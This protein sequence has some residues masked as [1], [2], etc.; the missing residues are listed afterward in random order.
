MKNLSCCNI[1][2]SLF[3]KLFLKL[4]VFA[5]IF[6]F[7]TL[8]EAAPQVDVA[9][10]K[11]ASVTI[12]NQSASF[13][14][15]LAITNTDTNN[16]AKTL[17]VSDNLPNGMGLISASGTDWACT[18]S[19]NPI[20]VTCTR[21]EL[22]KNSSSQ[23]TLNVTAPT[24]G[25]GGIQTITNT[26]TI[27][28]TDTTDNN[29]ANNSSSVAVTLNRPPIATDE[30]V[31]T[32]SH[33]AISGNVLTNDSDLDG[34]T[35][36]VTNTGTFT[37]SY[38]S[39]T[40][41]SNG[42][43]TYN[44]GYFSGETDSYTYTVSD[45]K[46]G[47]ATATL[48]I[49]IGSECT[50]T[51]LINAEREFCLRKQTVLFGD[52]VT[53]GNSILVPPT[54]QNS[55]VCDS[56]TTGAYYTDSPDSEENHEL[57]LCNY[58]PDSYTN[59]T[60]AEVVM[61]AT[62]KI[63]WA[64]LYLQSIV[65]QSDAASLA[66]MDIKIKNGN[67]SYVSAGTPTVINH[68]QYFY[69]NSRNYNAYSA[70]IDVTAILTS[71]NW[72]GGVYSV[73][74]VPVTTDQFVGSMV[75][76][77]YGAWT[78][79]VMYENMTDSLKSFSVYDG[80]EQFKYGNTD[81]TILIDNF[82]TP[83]SGNINSKVS[84]FAAEGDK[85]RTGDYF[86]G[87]KN[88]TSSWVDLGSPSNNAFNSGIISTGNRTPTLAN[89]Q[90]IDIKTYEVGT[91]GF[92]LLSNNQNSISFKFIGTN[93]YYMPSMLAFSTEVYHPRM[94]YYEKLY[95]SMGSELTT[96]SLV[97]KGSAINVK[98]LL[99]ND[100]NEPAEKVMLYRTFDT[101]LPYTPN[102][103]GY[104]LNPTGITVA[105]QISNTTTSLTDLLDS[106]IFDYSTPLNLFS[107]H[108]GTGAT[109]N[110]G[111]DFTLNQTAL[112][113]YATTA[114][115]DG[116]TSMSYQI[117]YTM[118]T[119]GYRYEG[120]LAKCEEFNNTFGVI[121]QV[122]VVGNMDVIENTSY[123]AAGSYAAADKNLYTKMV[124]K[125][126]NIEAVYLNSGGNEQIYNGTIG[127]KIVNMA[128]MLYL[129][130]P[131]TCSQ[132]NQLLWRGQI[133]HNTS[134]STA[135]I[136][137]IDV[138]TSDEEEGFLITQASL[139]KRIKANFI[140]YGT[141][142]NNT[143][144]LNCASSSLDSSLCL[145]PACMNSN[146]QILKV[147]PLAD[148]PYVAT[149]LY[150]DGGGSA[151]CDS[152]AYNGSCGG[153]NTT[154]SPNKYNNDIGCAMCL[155]DALGMS[156]CS[157]DN[158]SIR[159][160]TYTTTIS[161]SGTL[162]AGQ[163]FNITTI[164]KGFNNTSLT[165]YNGT[166]AIEPKTQITTCAV[167]DGNLTNTSGLLFNSIIF[168]GVDTNIS[169]NIKFGDIGVFDINITDS[170]WTN[171][172]NNTTK[173][174]SECIL[175]SNT[176]IADSSGK[177]GCLT[178]VNINKIVIPDHFDI[179][180]TLS[181]GSNGFT[182][183]NNFDTN[184]SF[185]KNISA[186]LN[187]NVTAKAFDINTT[188]LNYSSEC[189]AKSGNSTVTVSL[190]PI[191]PV[192][193]LM[194]HL[195]YDDTNN[196]IIGSTAIGS[197][198]ILPHPAARFTSGIGNLTYRLNF[199]RNVTKSTNPFLMSIP[200]MVV[201]DTDNVD[202]NNSIDNNATYVYGRTHAA[203][204]RY[205]GSSGVANIYF[206]SFCFGNDCNKTLLPNGTGSARVDDVRWYRNQSHIM[207]TD[208]AVGT[209]TQKGGAGTVSATAPTAANPAQTTLTYSGT[210][211]YPYKTTMEN[212]ASNWLIQNEFNPNATTNEFQVEFV[213]QTDWSGA[214][215]TNTTSKAKSTP[216]TNKRLDW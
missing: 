53:V 20:A 51:G 190:T 90:G 78:L 147:F 155:A 56:Y 15:T 5:Y 201:V 112:F 37:L 133:V 128:V 136:D 82:Y 30:T 64:G 148:Y 44:P 200:Q 22:P 25:A 173:S 142:I 121:P 3:C 48:Y 26:A 34:D 77:K 159:P 185:D 177:I 39:I 181:N 104:K 172:D 87:Y 79:V 158:F 183:L 157:S 152:N 210:K 8:L 65:R 41:S 10:T 198:L 18:Y 143:S 2:N 134:H 115:F 203:R 7:T 153:K 54:T 216:W 130:D 35:L 171:V 85:Y 95:D 108:A 118:P 74:N 170:T 33:T 4:K 196:S 107:L 187:A 17:T 84:V 40:I 182:Y 96:G 63:K 123:V 66:S 97:A 61:P 110:Q 188:T 162:I 24:S 127:N 119:I 135:I 105:D 72:N 194:Q 80:W 57:Y 42:A 144:D 191:T 193:N 125:S 124:N 164:A 163:D 178:R 16:A 102:S 206:E 113:N 99:K 43:F 149:C 132:E 62:G 174:P 197:S 180:G 199:D 211:G 111:G 58:K 47:T 103:T 88:S 126:F 213:G 31:S 93:D 156:G 91:G 94:C 6:L 192:G 83:T 137:D 28:T 69:A 14:Y 86:Q 12:I 29:S 150:G 209:V 36:I 1:N 106:D 161:P 169:N 154:I 184:A 98:V 139:S 101:G 60:S 67:S 207:P 114:N 55:T 166:A 141:L 13:S 202:G 179:N 46:G 38:G 160:D 71:H 146:E 50:A 214:H 129:T 138:D 167:P 11:T 145:V 23:I 189:Y 205:E 151:P 117:A 100:M 215:D 89:N 75:Q 32:P 122:V 81:A 165:G 120:E 49:S 21:S 168:N 212:N 140:D 52:M 175:Q 186:L 208:G 116:N 92:N 131:A 27:T 76:G 19:G 68:Q 176:N 59:A 204:Q 70:F 45:S 195:W 9:I 73:A 109:Y